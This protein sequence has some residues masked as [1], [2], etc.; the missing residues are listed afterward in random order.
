[1]IKLIALIAKQP[2]LSKAEFAQYYEAHHAPLVA[3]LLPMIHKYTRSYLPDTP[4]V[5]GSEGAANFDVLTELWFTDGT[6]LASF[7]QTIRTPEVSEAI[8]ADE[9]NFL[10]S[11][12]TQM[13]EVREEETEF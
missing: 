12:R 1:M 2:Q 3:R 8:R 10:L 5:P 4:E 11:A 9:A 7:W 13:Y 6:A